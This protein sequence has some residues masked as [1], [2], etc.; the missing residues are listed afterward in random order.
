MW[1]IRKSWSNFIKRT[2]K[3]M[4]SFGLMLKFNWIKRDKRKKK[5]RYEMK[6]NSRDKL[7]KLLHSL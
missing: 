3:G 7:A 6:I 5:M 4:I 2:Y 1:K